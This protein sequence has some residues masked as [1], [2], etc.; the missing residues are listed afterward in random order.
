MVSFWGADDS[1]AM[2]TVGVAEEL[3]EIWLSSRVKDVVWIKE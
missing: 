2:W 3:Q 1:S